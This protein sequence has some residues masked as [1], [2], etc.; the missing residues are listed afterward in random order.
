MT[1][2]LP[3][4]Y[5]DGVATTHS[6]QSVYRPFPGH[7]VLGGLFLDAEMVT[8]KVTKRWT[9]GQAIRSTLLALWMVWLTGLTLINLAGVVQQA[10]YYVRVGELM[11][12]NDRRIAE[13]RE[14]MQELASRM[15]DQDV[16]QQEILQRQRRAVTHR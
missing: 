14:R 6:H 12:Q 3:V 4:E 7:R 10:P 5:I 11:E 1:L 13:L 15:D 2:R 9:Q 16:R 8:M